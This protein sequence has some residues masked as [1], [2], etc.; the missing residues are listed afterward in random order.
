MD[1]NID[2]LFFWGGGVASSQFSAVE[3]DLFLSVF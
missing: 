1:S 2:L 3:N